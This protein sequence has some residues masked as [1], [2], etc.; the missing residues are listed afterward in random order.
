MIREAHTIMLDGDV[1]AEFH[2][3]EPG[4]SL[5]AVLNALLIDHVARVKLD[6]QRR[7]ALNQ[8]FRPPVTPRKLPCED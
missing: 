5:S 1:F 4:E 7:D 3:M 2:E 8:A 6:R